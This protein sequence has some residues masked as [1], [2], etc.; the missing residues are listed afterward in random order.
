M[1]EKI[2]LG[3]SSPQEICPRVS[4]PLRIYPRLPLPDKRETSDTLGIPGLAHG[5][6]FRANQQSI[7]SLGRTLDS[8]FRDLGLRF[9]NCSSLNLS[10]LLCKMG[11]II[12]F[13]SSQ[14][15]SED[16]IKSN[17]IY[18]GN[19]KISI[20][21]GDINSPLNSATKWLPG[22]GRVPSSFS[23][24]ISSSRNREGWTRCSL[25]R[26]SPRVMYTQLGLSVPARGEEGWITFFP[27]QPWTRHLVLFAHL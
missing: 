15:C 6:T 5:H 11:I 25:V 3:V 16:Q 23:P 12:L 1:N 4:L 10:L 27:E 9:R 24:S 2:F 26:F 18:F 14:S 13:P 17:Q 19:Y 22:F 20:K 21:I 7:G 8:E